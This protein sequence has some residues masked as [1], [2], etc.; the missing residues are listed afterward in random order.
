V[1]GAVVATPKTSI[2]SLSYREKSIDMKVSAP[3]LAA[4]SQLSQF[5]SKQGLAADI[6]S[7]TPGANGVEANLQIRT[8]PKAAK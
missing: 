6:Q 4:I 1:S 8:A 3:N 7:S 2:D 5:V